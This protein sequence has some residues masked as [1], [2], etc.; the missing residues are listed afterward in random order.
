MSLPE[1]P[2]VSARLM[3][4]IGCVA[5]TWAQFEFYL[6]EST[7]ELANVDRQAGACITA[8]MIGP[9]PR[10]KAL[11]S[12]LKWRGASSMVIDKANSFAGRA[13]MK[14]WSEGI[15]SF[16][17]PGLKGRMDHLNACMLPQRVSWFLNSSQPH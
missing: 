6:N 3:F 4:S 7:W 12:L 16:M 9:N 13:R 10:L 14:W 2:A 5:A 11:T 15:G 1:L 8:Q 17:I